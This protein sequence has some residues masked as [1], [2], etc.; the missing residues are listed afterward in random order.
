MVVL[1]VQPLGGVR[2]ALAIAEAALVPAVVSSALETSVGLAAG[3][4]L[5][6]A[7]PDLPYACGL[8]TATLLAGDVTS[9]APAARRRAASRCGRSTPRP[10]SLDRW[11]AL[12][13]AVARP[14]GRPAWSA[15]PGLA[16]ALNPATAMA[17]VVV[18][19]LVRHGVTEAGPQPRVAVGARWRWRA[20][21]HRDV[22]LH[23]RIDERSAG[24]LALGMARAAGRLIAAV[25]CTSGTAVANLLPAVVEADE[26]GVP[27]LLLTADRPSELRGTGANQT[28]DQVRL[29]GFAPRWACDLGV[30][31]ERVG[32][33]P[34]WRSTVSRAVAEAG[35]LGGAAPGPVHLNLPFREPPDARRGQPLRR[36]PRRPPRRRPLDPRPGRR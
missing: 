34:V 1:K 13:R 5:A 11:A 32:A 33:V 28:I 27:L 35:G 36:A 9:L 14:A 4:A 2:A 29:F 12:A 20:H 24:F 3:V 22:R 15:G 25:V 17:R 31:E 30:A 6:A 21:E 8:G 10:G 18:D 23:V 16:A 26:A 19:E 7:L